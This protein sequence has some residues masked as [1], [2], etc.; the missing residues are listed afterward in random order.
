MEKLAPKRN[1]KDELTEREAEATDPETLQDLEESFG[2]S[3]QDRSSK[4]NVASP[5]G[6]FDE[7]KRKSSRTET[8]TGRL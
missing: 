8:R 2:S 5:D 3:D 4:E 6:S 7:D 1:Q